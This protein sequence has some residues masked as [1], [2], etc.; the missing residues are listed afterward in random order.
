MNALCPLNDIVVIFGLICALLACVHGMLIAY[1]SALK[2]EMHVDPEHW[3]GV[4]SDERLAK[5]WKR[6]VR[7]YTGLGF[8]PAG[9]LIW[10]QGF[11]LLVVNSAVFVLF[12][13]AVGVSEQYCA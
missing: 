7:A 12:V 11:R 9:R 1:R 10:W 5:F 8:T 3:A 13:V 4:L 6:T 2:A